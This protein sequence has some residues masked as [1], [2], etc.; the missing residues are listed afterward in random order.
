MVGD[1]IGVTAGLS[2]YQLTTMAA[3]NGTFIVSEN[4]T[5]R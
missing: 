5:K 3:A 4:G 1:T 2:L